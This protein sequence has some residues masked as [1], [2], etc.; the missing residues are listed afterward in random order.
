M[1]MDGVDILATIVIQAKSKE[2][3]DQKVEVMFPLLRKDF[4]ESLIIVQS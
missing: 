3:A 4:K 1:Y 2:E